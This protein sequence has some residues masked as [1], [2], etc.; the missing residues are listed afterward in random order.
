VESQKKA[1]ALIAEA[2]AALASFGDRAETLKGLADFL[3]QRKN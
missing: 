1:D 3:V 2:H